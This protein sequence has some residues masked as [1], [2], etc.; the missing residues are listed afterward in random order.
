[1]GLPSVAEVEA[2]VNAFIDQHWDLSMTVGAWWQALTDARLMAPS[3][4]E[5][6]YGRGWPRE[7]SNAV[8][9]TLAVRDCLG[10]PT[11]LGMMLA[12][13]TIAAHGTQAQID[14]YV[15]RILSGQDAWCQ[16]FS[17]PG[18]GS[19][20]AGLQTKAERDGDEWIVNGQKVWTSGGQAADMGMLVARTDSGLPKHQG[21]TYFAI[22]MKQDGIDVRP[23]REITG[24]ALFNEVFLDHARVADDAIIGGLNEGWRVANTTLAVERSHLGA[25]A[26]PIAGAFPGSIAGHLDKPVHQ[27]NQRKGGEAGVPPV[28]PSL[29]R[30]YVE[31]ARE[32][33]KLDDPVIRDE[34][35]QLWTLVE[36]SRM[37]GLRAKAGS[38]RTGGEGNLAKL[39]MSEL[40]RR[41]SALGCR[42]LGPG[43]TL[44]GEDAPSKGVVQEVTMFA[45]GPAIYGGTDQVQRNIV[46]E[47][48]LGLPK[49]PGPARD[50]PFR[51][52]LTN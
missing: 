24:R 15:P 42:I 40:Y 30:R 52:L 7:L 4:P 18:A 48:V 29:W 41:F 2:E 14:R 6:A 39:S 27:F 44:L 51:E 17:E 31:L 13:P 1:M 10:P 47:R 12:A 33:G 45:P 50:T 5:G 28:G 38:G 37:N 35:A 8:L 21:L 16:L 22:P 43:A 36:V 25:A 32:Q 20:L 23:L 49:E 9:R 3:L 19:D 34:L 46:G 11:G 26:V